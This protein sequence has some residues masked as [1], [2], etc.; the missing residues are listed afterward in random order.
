MYAYDLSCLESMNI[1]TNVS[2]CN[3]MLFD[4]G[5]CVLFHLSCFFML[6][7]QHVVGVESDINALTGIFFDKIDDTCNAYKNPLL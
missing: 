6:K 7:P 2:L 5:D 4:G 1:F 3:I